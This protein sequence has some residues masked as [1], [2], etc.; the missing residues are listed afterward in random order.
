LHQIIGTRGR[1]VGEAAS[2]F[3]ERLGL[4]VEAEGFPRISGRI[5]GFLLLQDRPYSLDEL[6]DELKVSKASISTNARALERLGYV[7]RHSVPGDRRD[8]YQIVDEPW[9]QLM[10]VARAQFRNRVDLFAETRAALP[11]ELE[12]GRRRLAAWQDFF[13]HVVEQMDAH[14]DGWC[15][16][17]APPAAEG[18]GRGGRSESEEK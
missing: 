14:V 6:A 3:I 11:S 15:S 9:V 1:E 10:A 13:T 4:Q 17:Q 18:G 2:H 7:E 12:A 5:V 8:Y 16:R